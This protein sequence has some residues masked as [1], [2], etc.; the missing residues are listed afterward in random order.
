MLL[1]FHTH[2]FPHK[3]AEK[4]LSRLSFA[5]GG[6]RAYAD[7]TA[8]GLRRQMKDNGVDRSVVL[9]IATN[10]HQMKAVND[11]AAR[12][13]SDD[14]ISFGSVYPWAPDAEEE[15]ERIKAFGLKGV[16]FH[17]EYQ[18]FDVND[19]RMRPIYRKISELGLII[20]FHAG[21]D[22]GFAP[23]YH[24]RP[25]QLKEALQW[26]DSPA[27]AAHWGG[28]GYPE[29]VL[30]DLCGL[31]LYFDISFGYSQ[32]ARPLAVQI[33]EKHG[34]DKIL[35]GSDSP[36]H[37]PGFEKRLLDTLELSPEEREKICWSNGAGLLGICG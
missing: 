23:P 11:F 6:L 20:V 13:N 21:A 8:D 10:A 29:E 7:G 19:Q 33:L 26:I 1:D 28:A 32:I 25:S 15:L 14:L 37:E 2:C 5:A 31:P 18:E 3:L 16:K 34:T 22:L 9:N 24:C 30:R 4:A 27:V 36:W 17:P 35:F 12:I